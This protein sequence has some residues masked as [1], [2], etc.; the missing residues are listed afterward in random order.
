M[1]SIFLL[2]ETAGNDM[3]AKYA[4][5]RF[6]RPFDFSRHNFEVHSLDPKGGEELYKCHMCSKSFCSEIPSKEA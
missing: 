1:R 3:S 5:D 6:C 4:T 2:A